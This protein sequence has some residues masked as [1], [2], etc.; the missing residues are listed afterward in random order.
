MT[1]T[2]VITP[3][4]DD[5]LTERIAKYKRTFEADVAAV[6]RGLVHGSMP[7]PR[8]VRR[9]RLRCWKPPSTTISPNA[10]PTSSISPLP[11]RT[12]PIWSRPSC[13]ARSRS[14]AKPCRGSCRQLRG[15]G[16]SRPMTK[17]APNGS[18]RSSSF[19]TPCRTACRIIWY[20][21]MN[22]RPPARPWICCSAGLPAVFDQ[23]AHA[24]ETSP[25]DR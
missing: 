24:S 4:L 19:S 2:P 22:S 9:P 25:H 18:L 15:R 7:T 1:E 8:T 14:G 10:P 6:K 5:E 23:P 13:A 17:N 3:A 20:R 21:E 16:L 11:P 12:P